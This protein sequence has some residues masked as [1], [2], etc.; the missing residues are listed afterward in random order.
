MHGSWEPPFLQ[1][2]HQLLRGPST[3]LALVAERALGGFVVDAAVTFTVG[4]GADR[5]WEGARFYTSSRCTTYRAA[6]D[7]RRSGPKSAQ[8]RHTT[9]PW[10]RHESMMNCPAR[11]CTNTAGGVLRVEPRTVPQG[12]LLNTE[13]ATAWVCI[14]WKRTKRS[15]KG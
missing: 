7:R 3:T 10:R 4:R 12:N 11:A 5:L 1:Q 2:Q 14:Q 6:E 15:I 9:R 8:L 13:S